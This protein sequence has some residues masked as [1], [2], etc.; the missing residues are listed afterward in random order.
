MLVVSLMNM[1]LEL[2]YSFSVSLK[3]EAPN[4]IEQGKNLTLRVQLPVDSKGSDGKI[5]K[6]LVELLDHTH[7]SYDPKLGF[8]H[9]NQVLPWIE[10]QLRKAEVRVLRLQLDVDS[11]KTYY[12]EQFTGA[13]LA[14]L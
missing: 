10:S 7:L 14:P 13:A 3:S 8:H 4:S 9:Y 12:W 2:I 11:E 6:N 1:T 5:L